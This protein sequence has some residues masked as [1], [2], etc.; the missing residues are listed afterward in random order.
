MSK[1]DRAAELPRSAPLWASSLGA[2]A[3]VLGVY[4][5]AMH[6][7]EWMKQSVLARYAP[8]NAVLPSAVCPEDE[9]EEEGLTLAEC[10]H[11]VAKVEGYLQS[12]PRWFIG[13][14][15]VLALL[16][17]LAALGSI[18]IGA[19]LVSYRHWAPAAAAS[20]FAALLAIDLGAFLA[21]LN[22]GPIIRELY[23]ADVLLWVLLHLMLMIG[24]IAGWRHEVQCA[25]P[26]DRPR[27]E[28]TES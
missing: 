7:A 24:A 25:H 18:V 28:S 11:M 27:T 15:S 16:G 10:E 9:L 3:I 26:F 12:T 1:L 21:S 8:S 13:V 5:A 22:T 17:A 19:A 2:V 4:S 20:I 23:L 14:Q 6:G